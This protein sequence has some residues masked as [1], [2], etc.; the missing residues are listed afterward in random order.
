VVG[1][2]LRLSTPGDGGR[3][4]DVR[5]APALMAWCRRPSLCCCIVIVVTMFDDAA[6][7]KADEALIPCV[8][9]HE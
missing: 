6:A 7:S 2:R 9:A 1:V 8:H 4:P 3:V 5:Y